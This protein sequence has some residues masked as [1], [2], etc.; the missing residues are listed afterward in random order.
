MPSWYQAMIVFLILGISAG[1]GYGA[2]TELGNQ[3]VEIQISRIIVDF[4][5]GSPG[6]V[7]LGSVLTNKF[8]LEQ[9][10][11][12]RVLPTVTGLLVGFLILVLAY[13]V[14]TAIV[15]TRRT[16]NRNSKFPE[17]YVAIPTFGF[18]AI[19]IFLLVGTLL[20]PAKALAGGG[21]PNDCGGDVIASNKIAGRHLATRIPP[22][23]SVYWDG[24]KSVVPLLYLSDIKIYPPQINGDYS[25][26]LEGD[27]D[28]LLK[29]GRWSP[30]LAQE[31]ADQA[32]FILIEQRNYEGWLKDHVNSGAFDELEPTPPTVYCRD[33]AQIRIFRRK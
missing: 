17:L 24:G 12:R 15:Y 2:F 9:R 23:S 11:L 28:A 22:G 21:H 6:A 13:I 3:L 32:D 8:G 27:P 14:R 4:P 33:N 26:K 19:V 30:E 7:S 1:L 18:L 31:W 16:Q 5:N 29:H 25:F 20:S 10:D